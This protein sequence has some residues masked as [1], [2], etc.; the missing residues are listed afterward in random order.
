MVQVL[1]GVQW[2]ICMSF[3]DLT[4][5]FNTADGSIAVV[6]WDELET[7][8]GDNGGDNDFVTTGRFES[9][10]MAMT[11]GVPQGTVLLPFL[12]SLYYMLS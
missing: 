1:F 8:W 11:C 12:F 6:L 9:Y 2:L 7:W 4:T 5:A 10:W 3:L